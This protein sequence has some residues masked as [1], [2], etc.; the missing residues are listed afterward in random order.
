M[1]VVEDQ[2]QLLDKQIQDL[3]N[4]GLRAERNADYQAQMYA[5]LYV[6]NGVLIFIYF[7]LF[8]VIHLLF[9]EL[10]LRGIERSLLKDTIVF[11][12]FFVYPYAIYTIERY[13]YIAITYV[14]S[15]LAGR[16]YLYRFDR[17]FSSTSF[18]TNP[19][20]NYYLQSG[21]IGED[22]ILAMGVNGASDTGYRM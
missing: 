11:I 6:V 20:P 10:Y 15:W 14:G 19:D 1:G 16:T 13:I 21:T 8:G 18:Y 9:L 2:N 7:L 22:Q 3:K 4:A 17:V 5:S 12:L